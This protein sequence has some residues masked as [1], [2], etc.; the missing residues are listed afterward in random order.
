MRWISPTLDPLFPL[1][2]ITFA[3]EC[4]PSASPE[5]QS[6]GAYH[7]S[8]TNDFVSAVA[9]LL[10]TSMLYGHNQVLR[11]WRFP[12]HKFWP[13]PIRTLWIG[14]RS[15]SS[16]ASWCGP[17]TLMLSYVPLLQREGEWSKRVCA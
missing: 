2:T 11:I 14:R 8:P 17:F 3:V 7:S 13:V 10:G 5:F 15:A 1:G 6:R 4:S 16:R 9:N 12:S